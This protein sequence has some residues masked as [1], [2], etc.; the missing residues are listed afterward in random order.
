[1]VLFL[2]VLL[3]TPPHFWALSLNRIDEYA[4][5][6]VPMLP[7]VAGRA[8]T[9]RQILIYSILLFPISLLPWALGFAGA[10]YGATATVCGAT[11]IALALRLVGSREADRRPAHRLFA[12][13]ILYLFVLFAALLAGNGGDRRSLVVSARAAPAAVGPVDAPLCARGST[14]AKSEGV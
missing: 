3:W 8:E 2:I 14:Q 1:L 11:F 4:R 5:A 9:I 13:S 12:F 10:I 7:V 6:G